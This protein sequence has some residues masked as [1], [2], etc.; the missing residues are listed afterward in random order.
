MFLELNQKE[1]NVTALIDSNGTEA[2]YG[3]ILEF[4]YKLRQVISERTLVFMLCNNCVGAAVGYLGAL[5]NRIV[6]LMLSAST[7]SELL[8][9]LIDLYHPSYIWKPVSL[10]SGQEKALLEQY[11]YALIT[12]GLTPCSM[13]EELSLL[14]T[15]SGS[16]G[17]PKLVRHSYTNLEAQ[18]RNISAFFEL[19]ETEKPMLDLPIN[20]TYGL[21][22]LNSHLYAGATV[23]LTS[24]NVLDSGY[25]EFFKVN[26][27]TSITNV[28][29]YYEI[30]KK[31]RFFRMNLPSLR[32][33]SQGGGKLNE[34]LHQ[35]F[36]E[37]ANSS[38][39]RFI[40]TYGQT[41]GSA[42][43][44]YLPA[45]Y[46]IEKC[47]SIGKAI[48]NGHLFL[49]DEEGKEITEPGVVGEMVYQGPNVTLGYAQKGED[50]ALGDERCGLLHTGDMVKRDSDG[51]FYIAGRKSRFLKLCG[52]RVGLDE[53]ENMIKQ[54]FDVECAC[55]GNDEYMEIYVTTEQRHEDIK[56][57]IA[58]KTNI[59]SGVFLVHYIEKIPRNEAGK[60]LYNKLKENE[61]VDSK[62]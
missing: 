61:Y 37:Y 42:R 38:G 41:E 45:E 20:Y 8:E 36:A 17:S 29:Y 28:P 18:A 11:E 26:K 7:D 5:T 1:K 48:P 27:A 43:M 44:A 39:K 59:N 50:L 30:L 54:A 46:A 21:S 35:E 56:K 60:I 9:R 16:T 12:T 6:P 14:L 33:L 51:F 10:I 62:K 15:T 40:V 47:G 24:L 32:T 34:K 4:S 2:S 52:F 49:V 57:Y 53:C 13:Y 58:D 25:W 22:V 19:D 55:V 31:L 3:D 23:L